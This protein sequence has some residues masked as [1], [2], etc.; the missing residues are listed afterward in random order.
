MRPLSWSSSIS[1]ASVRICD[2]CPG[3]LRADRRRILRGP[4]FQPDESQPEHGKRERRA[5]RPA[6]QQQR[7]DGKG[8][9]APNFRKADASRRGSAVASKRPPKMRSRRTATPARK[10]GMAQLSAELLEQPHR[11]AALVATQSSS[12]LRPPLA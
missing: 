11:R 2:F 8:R 12:A 4:I 10:K 7:G 6:R 3:D 1:S 9:H 5:E